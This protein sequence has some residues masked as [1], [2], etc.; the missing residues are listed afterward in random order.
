MHHFSFCSLDLIFVFCAF[1]FTPA[2]V[3]VIASLSHDFAVRLQLL[4]GLFTADTTHDDLIGI[5]GL[6]SGGRILE[7]LNRVSLDSLLEVGSPKSSSDLVGDYM[8]ALISL[9]R[10]IQLTGKD[11]GDDGY[12]TEDHGDG[13]ESAYQYSSFGS[14][15]KTYAV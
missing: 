7:N 10:H 4:P 8:S 9:T 11:D 15:V 2:A 5:M 6:L 12:E 1:P 3:S 13:T 14:R